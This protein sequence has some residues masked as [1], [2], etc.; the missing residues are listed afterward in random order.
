MYLLRQFCSNRVKFFYDTQKTQTEKMMDQ[1][2]EI[3]IVI[4]ENFL[5]F[6]KRRRA[7]DVDH[8]GRCQTRLE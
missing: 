2:V 7:A 4:F 3:R 5:K 1:N 6:S 8:Y